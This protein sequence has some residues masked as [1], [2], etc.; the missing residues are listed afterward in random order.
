MPPPTRITYLTKPQTRALL[1]T[2]PTVRD[3]A[4][5]TV[6]YW[7]G[8]RAS[9]VGLLTLADWRPESSRLFVHRLKGS[10]SGEYKVSPDESSALRAWV[11]VRGLHPGPLF[12]SSRNTPISR[13]RLH[14]LM[15]H[16]CARAS[17]PIPHPVNHFHVLRHSIAVHLADAG[18]DVA[19]IQ[20]W[21]GHRSIS[22]TMIYVQISNRRRDRN[23][24][25]MYAYT[26]A[27][28]DWEGGGQEGEGEGLRAKPKPKE[29]VRTDGPRP[30]WKANKLR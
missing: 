25:A 16:Y 15:R 30:N 2:I 6:A 17:P 19:L 29:G 13:Q 8:L 3:R 11:K 24:E 23:A 9:E 12:P 27:E 18:T 10:S 28:G 22:N 1:S 5:W 20:D 7:R 21:L 4:I 14:N 26:E